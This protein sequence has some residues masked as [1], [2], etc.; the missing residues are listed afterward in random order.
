MSKYIIQIIMAAFGSM[1]FSIFFNIK[2]S[3]L[4]LVTIGGGRH[5]GSLSGRPAF[6]S[7]RS[8]GTSCCLRLCFSDGRDICKGFENP[9][10]YTA[11]SLFDPSDPGRKSLLHDELFCQGTG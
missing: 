11:G 8:G 3:K 7:E 2:R 1:G 4:I 10:N 6:L 5:L 9:C